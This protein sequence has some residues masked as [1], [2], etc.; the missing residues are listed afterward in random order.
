MANSLYDKAREGFLDGSIVLTTNNIKAVLVDTSTYTPNLATHANLSDI[1]TPAR[2]AT[3]GNLTGK[4]VTNGVFDADDLT[5][6]ALG[7]ASVE[8]IVL[9]KDTGTA[10]TSRLIHY[11]DT[12]TGLPFTPNGGD[13][14]LAWSNAAN[15]I[16]KI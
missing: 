12:G 8:A 1:P 13:L 11:M 4:T 10:S 5:F 6:A 3:S 2:V 9:Y 15:K 14:N 16:F 7:G